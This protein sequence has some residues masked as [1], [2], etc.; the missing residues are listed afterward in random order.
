MK[1]LSPALLRIGGTS[2][3]WLFY[4]EPIEV[5][6]PLKLL[7]SAHVMMC[8]DVEWQLIIFLLLNLNI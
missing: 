4:N 3:D 5:I 2:A 1:A 8:K 6:Y 7:P